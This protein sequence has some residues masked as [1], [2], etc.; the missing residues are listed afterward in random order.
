MCNGTD[1]CGERKVWFRMSKSQPCF[2][3][4]RKKNIPVLEK[5]AP[6]LQKLERNLHNELHSLILSVCSTNQ[7]QSKKCRYHCR[8]WDQMACKAFWCTCTVSQHFHL[9]L[10]P[11]TAPCRLAAKG[12]FAVLGNPVPCRLLGHYFQ[13]SA[14]R[15]GAVLQNYHCDSL[16]LILWLTSKEGS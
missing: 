8:S 1:S 13:L 10:L 16:N 6:R 12:Q 5:V 11:S 2:P 7:T 3:A 4:S 9:L 15:L 14:L